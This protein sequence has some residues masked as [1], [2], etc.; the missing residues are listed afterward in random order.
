[1]AAAA[2]S[3]T[4]LCAAAGSFPPEGLFK[5]G[6]PHKR[7]APLRAPPA[8]HP[9]GHAAAHGAAAAGRR[10]RRERSESAGRGHGRRL[11]P[12]AKKGVDYAGYNFDPTVKRKPVH[13]LRFP[14][15]I[16]SCLI[17]PSLSPSLPPSTRHT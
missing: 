6:Q 1:L 11:Y 15:I 13:S 12:T 4:Q 3:P 10:A 16:S 17:L 2:P 9:A 14:S 5:L 8:P 7:P